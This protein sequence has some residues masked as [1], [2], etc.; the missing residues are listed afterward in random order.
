MQHQMPPIAMPLGC[1]CE[2]NCGCD[3]AE[4]GC[5][6]RGG[7]VDRGAARKAKPGHGSLPAFVGSLVSLMLAYG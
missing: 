2:T 1:D 5:L 7:Q 3:A 6:C 4:Q